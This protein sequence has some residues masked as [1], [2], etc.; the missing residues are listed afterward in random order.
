VRRLDELLSVLLKTLQLISR[1][2]ERERE[3]EESEV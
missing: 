3:H 1:E 2:R